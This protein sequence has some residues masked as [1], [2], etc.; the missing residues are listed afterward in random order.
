MIDFGLAQL[1]DPDGDNLVYKGV[2]TGDYQAPE[3]FSG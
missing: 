1:I 3:T 2:L